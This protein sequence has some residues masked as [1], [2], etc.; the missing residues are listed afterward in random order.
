MTDDPAIGNVPVVLR[1]HEWTNRAFVLLALLGGL[2]C[3]FHFF[4]GA[5]IFCAAAA[6]PRAP[7]YS[8]PESPAA[9]VLDRLESVASTELSPSAGGKQERRSTGDPFSRVS[10]LL[11]LNPPSSKSSRALAGAGFI[12]GIPGHPGSLLS[13]LAL[14][15]PGGDALMQ[16]FYRG[17]SDFQNAPGQILREPPEPQDKR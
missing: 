12:L 4:N 17:V 11:S 3:L 15:A 14:P 1:R 6:R 2:F 5:G 9:A 13:A 10:A 7:L 8:Q 16:A